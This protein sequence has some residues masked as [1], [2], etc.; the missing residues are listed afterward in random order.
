[1]SFNDNWSFEVGCEYLP[2]HSLL[3]GVNGHDL[4][5]VCDAFPRCYWPMF[6]LCRAEYIYLE[7]FSTIRRHSL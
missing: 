3:V 2:V 4:V 6:P 1:M 7:P 5:V